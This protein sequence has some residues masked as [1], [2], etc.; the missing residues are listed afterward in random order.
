VQAAE[1]K[2]V[3]AFAYHSDMAKYGPKAQLTATTH[4]WGEFYTRT[5]AAVLDGTWK[6]ERVWGGMKDGMIKLA[7]L[8]PAI[9]ADVQTLVRDIEAKIT[10][11]SFHPFTG[12]VVDQGGKE[13]LAAG[14]VMDDDALGKMDYFVQGVSSRLPNAK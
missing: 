8:N 5:V 14:A 2:G 12:P 11:G 3:H 1:E 4:H 7:P 13:R 10:T 6:P 9:P